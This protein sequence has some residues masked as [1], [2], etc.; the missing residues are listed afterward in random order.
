MSKVYAPQVPSKYDPATK[1]WVPSIN[2]D[3]AKSF[4]E[5]VVMLPPNAN[6][7]HINPLIAALREVGAKVVLITDGDVAG[8][9]HTTQ[10][11]TGI[12]MYLGSGGAPE[13]VLAAAALK[14]VGG[15]FQGRLIFRNDEERARA[16]KPMLLQGW[17]HELVGHLLA[18]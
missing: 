3:H 5:L 17:R 11:E 14:C 15:H 8:V 9:I 16:D 18:Q 6:R 10:P 4:G 1:L 7:L 13:G 12:D 2:L